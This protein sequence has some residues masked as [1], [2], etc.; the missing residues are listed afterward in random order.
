MK[1]HAGGHAFQHC[2]LRFSSCAA[3]KGAN[4]SARRSFRPVDRAPSMMYGWPDVKD[5]SSEAS[6]EARQPL[7]RVHTDD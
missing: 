7:R 6:H 2:D 5:A 3:A 4:V 1:C